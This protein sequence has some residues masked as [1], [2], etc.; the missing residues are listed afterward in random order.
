MI[1]DIG[2]DLVRVRRIKE[3]LERWGD[4]FEKKIFTTQ[5]INNLS[6]EK[7]F[8]HLAGKFAAKESILKS[9]GKIGKW[10]DIE[11]LKKKN[12]K[13]YVKLQGKTAKIARKKGIEKILITL[14]HDGEYAIAEAITIG[15]QT[16]NKEK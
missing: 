1:K 4:R 11:I 6:E 3:I 2:I 10:Q 16:N 12:G 9:L 8:I 13:P 7:K 15:K 5:E 14:S